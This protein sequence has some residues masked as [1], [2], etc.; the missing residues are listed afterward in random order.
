L[1]ETGTKAFLCFFMMILVVMFLVVGV[2]IL[3]GGD[4]E[5]MLGIFGE[6]KALAL[7]FMQW[8]FPKLVNATSP[9]GSGEL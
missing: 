1:K 5:K 6:C 7:K 3:A 2:Y 9:L 4:I 8:N